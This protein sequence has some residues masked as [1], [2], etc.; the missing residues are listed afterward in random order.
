MRTV[1]FRRAGG[2][3]R[4]DDLMWF[5]SPIFA[6]KLRLLAPLKKTA[7]TLIN[8]TDNIMAYFKYHITTALS[9]GFY[10]LFSA[11]KRKARGYRTC[12]GFAAI[13]YFVAGN[14]FLLSSI[15]SGESAKFGVKHSIINPVT[16]KGK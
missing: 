9:E 5:S 2:I 8:L 14:L 11:A 3:S 6:D 13:I 15:H 10:S 1:I 12:K 4:L 7:E 16:E